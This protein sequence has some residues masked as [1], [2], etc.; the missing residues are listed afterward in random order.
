MRILNVDELQVLRLFASGLTTDEIA[1]A[2]ETD[3]ATV[4]DLLRVAARKLQAR[5]RVHAAVIAAKLGLVSGQYALR[6]P[7]SS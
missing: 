1:A 4:Q 6:Q 7:V 3:R 5:N 2:M